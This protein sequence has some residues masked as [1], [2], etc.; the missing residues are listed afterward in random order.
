MIDYDNEIYTYIRNKIK[1]EFPN[2]TVTGN[3]DNVP[4]KFPTVAISVMS[5]VAYNKTRDTDSNENHVAV[6]IQ[7]DVFSNKKNT[8][9]SECKEIMAVADNAYEELGFTR[10][11]CEFIPN[12]E[13]N[14]TRLTARHRAVIGKN[15]I[16][17]RR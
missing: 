7:T 6:T 2:V 9:K 8:P 4:T 13:S 17:Y 14:I 5:N 10:N 3:T 12:S 16:I 15:G 1:A 11:F